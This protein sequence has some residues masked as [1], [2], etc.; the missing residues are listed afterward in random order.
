VPKALTLILLFIVLVAQPRQVNAQVLDDTT[1]SKY[2]PKTT[3]YFLEKDLYFNNKK[4]HYLDTSLYNIEFSGDYA[5][6]YNR[7]LKD[8]GNLGTTTEPVFFSL[9]DQIGAGFGPSGFD[10]YAFNPQQLRYFNTQ[11]PATSV[12]YNIGVRGREI[13]KSLFTRNITPNLNV[14]F[15]YQRLTAVRNINLTQQRQFLA[16]HQSFAA[17]VNFVSPNQRFIAMGNFTHLNHLLYE[18]GGIRPDPGDTKDSLFS[19]ELEKANL[20]IQTRNREKRNGW[21]LYQ[22]YS[23]DS[24]GKLQLFHIFDRLKQVNRFTDEKA[25]FTPGFY[26]DTVAGH[27]LF[28]VH[29]YKSFE[30][31]FGLKGRWGRFDYAGYYRRRDLRYELNEGKA[32]V[33][34]RQENYLGGY[35]MG[36]VLDSLKLL[37][38]GEI[39][40]GRDYLISGQIAA[41][42]F[43]VGARQMGY[44]PTLQQNF[45]ASQIFGWSNNFNI[46]NAFNIWGS[47]QFKQKNWSFSPEAEVIN[48]F[49]QIYFSEDLKPVQADKSAQIVYLTANLHLNFKNWHF[50]N[51]FRQTLQSGADVARLPAQF[52]TGR[53]YYARDLFGNKGISI[54]TGINLWWRDAW[55][56]NNYMPLGMIWYLQNTGQNSFLLDA[57]FLIEP[58]INLRIK[59]SFLYLRMYN[60]NQGLGAPGYFTTP[61]YTGQKRIVEFGVNWQFFD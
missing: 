46:Q 18:T 5:R 4:L 52:Y 40:P 56:G 21:H 16:D 13:F 8:L 31:K 48:L 28:S 30:N 57:H 47:Y 36:K 43:Q 37:A 45:F 32:D 22:Q 44:S 54:E 27:F 1:S 24:T 35:L 10:P 50:H 39:N 25:N 26:P 61:Y 55:L 9:P 49:N 29:T 23:L 17:Q 34:Y 33:P 12:Q 41:R 20:H 59:R 58:F 60:A 6:K 3:R 14:G 19:F 2:G 11:S 7:Q 38:Q 42:R 51:R 15:E 53:W